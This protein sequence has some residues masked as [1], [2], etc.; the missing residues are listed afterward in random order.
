M[1]SKSRNAVDCTENFVVIK[2]TRKIFM[3]ISF[4]KNNVLQI[5]YD[6]KENR[7]SRNSSV[8]KKYWLRMKGTNIYGK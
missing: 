6:R 1:F 4:I 7:C 3:D 5:A 2:L 8:P